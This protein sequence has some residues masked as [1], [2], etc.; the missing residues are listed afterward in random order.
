MQEI[1]NELQRTKTAAL[2]STMKTN[3]RS[4]IIDLF[5]KFKIDIS[6]F[7]PLRMSINGRVKLFLKKNF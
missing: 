6:F 2:T 7:R 1:F 5:Y 3:K 4:K